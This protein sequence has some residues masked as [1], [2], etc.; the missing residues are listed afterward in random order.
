MSRGD[1]EEKII[2]KK[3]RCSKCGGTGY[4]WQEHTDDGLVKIVKRC[5]NP[6]CGHE[7]LVCTYRQPPTVTYAYIEEEIE[8]F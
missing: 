4:R 8:M 3:L 7:V 1:M 6:T 2:V 5:S